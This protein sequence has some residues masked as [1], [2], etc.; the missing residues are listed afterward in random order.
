MGLRAAQPGQPGGWSPVAFVSPA[1]VLKSSGAEKRKSRHLPG[2]NPPGKLSNGARP[3]DQKLLRNVRGCLVWSEP[4]W[5]PDFYLHLKELSIKRGHHPGIWGA[6][7]G[8]GQ[9]L[10]LFG[11]FQGPGSSFRVGLHALVVCKMAKLEAKLLLQVEQDILPSH[12]EGTYPVCP[13]ALQ[14][15]VLILLLR[16]FLPQVIPPQT[17]NSKTK[18]VFVFCVWGFSRNL[19]ELM[20]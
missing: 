11:Q 18:I 19:Q 8:G 17:P 10:F 14:E 1:R 9:E 2:S 20:N 15:L 6:E 16:S 5:G 13:L 12:V 3:G 4:F 7:F